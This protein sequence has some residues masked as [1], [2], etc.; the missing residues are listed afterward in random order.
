MRDLRWGSGAGQVVEA[1]KKRS[2]IADGIKT[3]DQIRQAFEAAESIAGSK[4]REFIDG[5]KEVALMEATLVAVTGAVW[6][7]AGAISVLKKALM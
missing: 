6:L 7:T 2:G 3:A 5:L 1:C 4:V